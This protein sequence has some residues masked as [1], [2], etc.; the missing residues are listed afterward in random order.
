MNFYIKNNL[1]VVIEKIHILFFGH[2]ISPMMKNFLKNISWTSFGFLASSLILFMVN[3]LAGRFLGPSGYGEYNFILSIASII[4]LFV[5][6]GF[7]SASVKYISESKTDKDKNE[8]LSGSLWAI[9]FLAIVVLAVVFLAQNI[10]KIFFDTKEEIIVV[11]VSYAVLLGI[12]RILSSFLSSLNFFKFQSAI[13]IVESLGVI[14]LFSCLFI[15]LD[16]NHY[17]YYI[18]SLSF[19]ILLFCLMTILKIRKRVLRCNMSKILFLKRYA[20]VAFL[21]ALAIATPV[22]LIKLFIGKYLSIQDLGIFSAYMAVTAIFVGQFILILNNVFFPMV[23]SI[24]DK[25]PIINKINKIS[26]ISFIPIAVIIFLVAFFMLKFY[27]DNYEFNIIYVGMLSV[28]SSLLLI[29][30]FYRVIVQTYNEYYFKLHKFNYVNI[31]FLIAGLFLINILELNEMVYVIGM[32][33]IYVVINFF[34]LF[35]FTNH[36]ISKIKI[37]E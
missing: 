17:L 3:V 4:S 32:Y 12:R 15:I 34:V 2:K 29:N 24:D 20:L 13:T 7:D 33:M 26:F 6:M 36:Y 5:I 31:L 18:T 23:S 37:Y 27:G 30:N 16:Y 19:G 9:I 35:F 11:S 10:F 21:T 28:I 8:Y 14:L 25:R 22:S 1:R